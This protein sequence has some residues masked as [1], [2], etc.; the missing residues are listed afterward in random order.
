MSNADHNELERFHNQIDDLYQNETHRLGEWTV[1][2]FLNS[3]TTSL[4]LMSPYSILLLSIKGGDVTEKK[5]QVGNV[6]M[7]CRVYR[8]A[9]DH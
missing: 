1:G 2:I 6:W 8:L 3:R 9:T 5:C 7:R 4:T